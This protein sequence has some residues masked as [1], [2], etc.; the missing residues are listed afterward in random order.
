MRGIAAQLEVHTSNANWP[1]DS[2]VGNVAL[3]LPIKGTGA[4]VLGSRHCDPAMRVPT[5]ELSQIGGNWA[6]GTRRL[7]R[8]SSEQAGE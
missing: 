1:M 3:L 8:T 5:I 4:A 7:M 2:D 6:A